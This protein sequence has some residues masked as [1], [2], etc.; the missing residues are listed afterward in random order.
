[1][2]PS[3]EPSLE[4]G[5]AAATLAAAFLRCRLRFAF[6][7]FP[8][9]RRALVGFAAMSLA[10][11]SPCAALVRLRARCDTGRLLCCFG[12]GGVCQ[13]EGRVRVFK[14]GFGVTVQA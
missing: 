12:A 9:L 8:R 10:R 5:S 7:R 11:P 1:M 6:S 4:F 13:G 14:G 3:L 2:S